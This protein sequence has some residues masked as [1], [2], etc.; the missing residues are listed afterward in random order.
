MPAILF[1]PQ[2]SWRG[3]RG[4]VA[5]ASIVLASLGG[6]AAVA[7]TPAFPPAASMAA[8]TPGGGIVDAPEA[9]GEF[10]GS[11]AGDTTLTIDT[12]EELYGEV[13][14]GHWQSFALDLSG[15]VFGWG[16]GRVMG[17]ETGVP[18][19]EQGH[20]GQVPLPTTSPVRRLTSDV[21]TTFAITESGELFRL[22]N[23][24]AGGPPSETFQQ[25]PFPPGVVVIHVEASSRSAF[26]VSADGDL[27]AWGSRSLGLGGFGDVASLPARIPLPDHVDFREVAST[28]NTNAALTA[29]GDL[30]MW[31]LGQAFPVPTRVDIAE[32]LTAIS[33]NLFRGV[34]LGKSG[35]IYPM[36]GLG[37]PSTGLGEAISVPTLGAVTQVSADGVHV[38]ALDS[39]GQVWAWGGNEHG[40]L[41]DGTTSPADNPQPVHIPT[42][43][44]ITQIDA[45]Y[46]HNIVL[47]EQGNAFT[48]GANQS[49]E[50]GS[51]SEPIV[52]AARS[53]ESPYRVAEVSFDGIAATNLQPLSSRQT[54][55][56][57]P[58][59]GPGF[60][61]IVLVLDT[62]NT[63]VV[64]PILMPQR[65]EYV[66]PIELRDA[67]LHP[68]YGASWSVAL[69]DSV[70]HQSTRFRVVDGEL[71]P[72]LE[73]SPT[74]VLS[75]NAEQEMTSEVSVEAT[76]VIGTSS[77][78]LKLIVTAPATP[79]PSTL[80]TVKP[81][82]S[83]NELASTG[84]DPSVYLVGALTLVM[85]GG[86][87]S[88][89][90]K[91]DHSTHTMNA[92]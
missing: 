51:I 61:D 50:S 31:G 17:A 38:L 19:G 59:H 63:H 4:F 60:V 87:L 80:P 23:D 28:D 82:G 6:G 70:L 43:E 89:Q 55:V 65:Y 45:G 67:V 16:S 44:L 25:V 47:D 26:A 88:R 64:N 29:D 79:G 12:P 39:D 30:Y 18:L 3:F 34:A 20:P 33:A 68:T 76:N 5:G 53:V 37:A 48:W 85:L 15:R 83:A 35:N 32:P 66:A 41:G 24:P 69:T 74:G 21:G 36:T 75:G 72:G 49:L 13:V 22:G 54:L 10:I 62:F 81:E 90:R 8:G 14:A 56:T 1:S 73:L 86:V 7:A 11:A 92:R 78:T 77:A 27:Y 91:R 71:P 58:P 84:F 40:V 42:D 9:M 2:R 52:S 57:P 46:Q